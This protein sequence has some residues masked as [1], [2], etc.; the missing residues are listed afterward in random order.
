VYIAAF[1]MSKPG[2]SKHLKVARTT[3]TTTT[4]TLA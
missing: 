1:Q 3:V 4:L 2:I